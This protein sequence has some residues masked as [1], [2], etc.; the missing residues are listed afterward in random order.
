MKRSFLLSAFIIY[1]CLTFSQTDPKA[2]EILKGVSAKYKSYKSLSATFKLNLLDKKTNKSSNQNGSVTLKGTMYNLTMADQQVMSDS[3]LVWT[4]LK[5]SNEVQISESDGKSDAL[6]P[7]NIFTLYEKGFKSKYIGEKKVGSTD[8]QQIE[9][10]PEDNKKN[11]F[12]IL[13]NIA[14]ADKYVNSAKVFDKNGNIYTYSITRFTP[15]VVVSDGLFT[16][17]KKKYPGVEVVDLR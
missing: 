13:I 17:E 9:L 1:S 3:K 7:T 15:N 5:E 8:I 10:A 16:F 12:K 11:Y 2:Q 14:K 6:S 4:Y